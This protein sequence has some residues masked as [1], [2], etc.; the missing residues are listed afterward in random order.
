MQTPSSWK[1]FLRHLCQGRERMVVGFIT[2]Y[3]ISVYH[4]WC[5]EFE[6][7][8]GRGVQHYVIITQMVMRKTAEPDLSGEHKVLGSWVH[9]ARY[10]ANCN[11]I[12]NDDNETFSNS[13]NS[14]T[15]DPHSQHLYLEV[16]MKYNFVDWFCL[17]IYLW[18]LTFPL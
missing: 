14:E 9:P 5:C 18:V 8:S 3:A 2:T 11:R 4:R 1:T 16:N 13:D 10:I 15:H 6:S 12:Y 17:F 7:R